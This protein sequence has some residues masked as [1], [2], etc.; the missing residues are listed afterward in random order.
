AAR[1]GL[2]AID[3][4][5]NPGTG[6]GPTYVAGL[7]VPLLAPPSPHR[8]ASRDSKKPNTE[9]SPCVIVAFAAE[10][11]SVATPAHAAINKFR[12]RTPRPTP[13]LLFT[14]YSPK[15]DCIFRKSAMHRLKR[16]CSTR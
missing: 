3:P 11:H 14:I 10:V 8:P 5:P 1:P 4:V 16:P 12:Q 15:V 13:N 9:K 6:A 7:K 2:D